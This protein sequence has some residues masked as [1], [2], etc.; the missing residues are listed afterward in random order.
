MSVMGKEY[1]YLI[2]DNAQGVTTITL[3]DPNKLNSLNL[4]MQR[5]LLCALRHVRDDEN[6][7]V[8]IITGAGEKA[9]CVG[10]DISISKEFCYK[11]ISADA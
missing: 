1:Q 8:I 10:A 5:E 2:Y 4:D 9:F 6:T 11:R 7:K 3:N